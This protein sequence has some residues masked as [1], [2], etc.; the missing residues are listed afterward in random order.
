[1]KLSEVGEKNLI[2]R[3]I[4]LLREQGLE[5]ELNDVYY[6]EINGRLIAVSID[7]FCESTWILPFLTWRDV[8]KKALYAAVS[9]L[10]VKFARPRAFAASLCF[11]REHE[12]KSSEEVL[13][14]LA[15]AAQQMNMRILKLDTNEG[16]EFSIHVCVIGEARRKI[17]LEPR[18]GQD[19]YTIPLYGY[20]GIVF[21]LLAEKRLDDFK[22][23][24]VVRRGI[25]VL[26]ETLVPLWMKIVELCEL[27][28]YISASTDTSDGLG[29]SLW[30]A[31]ERGNVTIDIEA[32]PAPSE[33]IEFCVQNNINP[34]EAVFNGAEDYLPVLFLRA[35]PPR[36]LLDEIGLVKIGHVVRC[37]LSLV[38]F[39]GE[40]LRFRG[41]EYFKY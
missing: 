22:R 15:D 8:G 13:K 33:V 12:L 38:T 20:T 7:G 10:V 16:R 1:M 24:P 25:D 28:E 14:G 34:L 32:L 35:E 31:A 40:A 39:R 37:G 36:Y 17:G 23:D 30:I 11:T 9:D 18:P 21:K 19:V 26:K 2:K 3:F 6:L 4:A 5:Y 41:W 27:E 29:A